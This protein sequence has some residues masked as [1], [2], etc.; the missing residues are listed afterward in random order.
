M[1]NIFREHLACFG[2]PGSKYR[3]FL[4]YQSN[5]I[6]QK[7]KYEGLVVFQILKVRNDTIKNIEYH[8][9]NINRSHYI[10]ILSK[11]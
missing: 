1:G 6:N 11:S 3:P 7:T 9:L 4:I 8:L 2:G 5:A 10:A